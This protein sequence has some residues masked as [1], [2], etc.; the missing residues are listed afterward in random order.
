MFVPPWN[1]QACKTRLSESSA[2]RGLSHH[3]GQRRS[4]LSSS[5]AATASGRRRPTTTVGPPGNAPRAAR[6]PRRLHGGGWPRAVERLSP[7]AR[8]QT[9]RGG[10]RRRHSARPAAGR[11]AERRQLEGSAERRPGPGGGARI[12]EEGRGGAG[13]LQHVGRE[14][15]S[16]RAQV[17][18]STGACRPGRWRPSNRRRPR[19][20]GAVPIST[21]ES[22]PRTGPLPQARWQAH[23][24]PP[25]LPTADRTR[26]WPPAPAP[27]RCPIVRRVAGRR[28]LPNPSPRTG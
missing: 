15:H 12:T 20:A 9:V 16:R 4:P 14:N 8:L 1:R 13:A 28:P 19:R 22:H 5:T 27:R 25:S 7:S 23:R 17:V 2:R 10:R 26:I 21:A 24:S 18:R 11:V 3:S 6:H